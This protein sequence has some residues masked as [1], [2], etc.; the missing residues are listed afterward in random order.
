M[1]IDITEMGITKMISLVLC[2]KR[3]RFNFLLE[4]ERIIDYYLNNQV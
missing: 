4:R 2:H 1:G 3:V